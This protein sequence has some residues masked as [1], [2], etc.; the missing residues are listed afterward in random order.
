MKSKSTYV[1]VSVTVRTLPVKVAGLPI[2]RSCQEHFM[3]CVNS[4]T[5]LHS[6]SQEPQM[7]KGGSLVL[8][9]EIAASTSAR[10][11]HF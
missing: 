7:Y 4:G 8:S 6:V 1:S 10:P 2:A 11:L 9:K 5:V 3:A